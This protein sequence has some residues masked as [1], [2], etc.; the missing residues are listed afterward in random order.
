[1]LR[2]LHNLI[3]YRLSNEETTMRTLNW[4]D[5]RRIGKT[6][7]A[8]RWYPDADIA[9]YFEGL[10]APSRAWPHSYAKAAQTAKFARWLTAQRPEIAAKFGA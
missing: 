7:S 2:M 3:H 1:M 6:D 10:R 8:N 9:E 5:I 4:T